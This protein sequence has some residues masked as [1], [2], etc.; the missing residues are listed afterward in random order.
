MAKSLSLVELIKASE[1]CS[2]LADWVIL[3]L[4][5][6]VIVFLGVILVAQLLLGGSHL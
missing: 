1:A 2:A 5:G 3:G 4:P 6:G